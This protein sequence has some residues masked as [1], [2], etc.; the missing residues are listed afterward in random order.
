M[1]LRIRERAPSDAE[2]LKEIVWTFLDIGQT[3]TVEL[4]SEQF[5]RETKKVPPKDLVMECLK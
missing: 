2:R 1:K 5:Y 3:P 4:L